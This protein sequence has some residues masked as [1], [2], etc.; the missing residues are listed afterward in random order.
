MNLGKLGKAGNIYHGITS[1]AKKSPLTEETR[2]ML[3][4]GYAECQAAAGNVLKR[5]VPNYNVK[6]RT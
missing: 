6:D 3:L 1:F 2:V 5:Y 4:L